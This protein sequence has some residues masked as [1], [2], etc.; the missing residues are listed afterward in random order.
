[1]QV[2][3]KVLLI[4]TWDVEF[5]ERLYGAQ[6][7]HLPCKLATHFHASSINYMDYT[8]QTT[9]SQPEGLYTDQ[10]ITR[11]IP[12]QQLKLFYQIKRICGIVEI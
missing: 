2:R 7:N 9:E 6:K 10:I 3:R 4:I 8:A 12:L 1:M 11:N 5:V